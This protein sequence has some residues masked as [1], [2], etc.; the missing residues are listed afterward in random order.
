M[1]CQQQR[2]RQQGQWQHLDQASNSVL[3]AEQIRSRCKR[4]AKVSSMMGTSKNRADTFGMVR[5]CK[6]RGLPPAQSQLMFI[7]LPGAGCRSQQ[8][9]T[10]V[11]SYA[12]TTHR[13]TCNSLGLLSLACF[14]LLSRYLCRSSSMGSCRPWMTC[15]D[16][17]KTPKLL[18]DLGCGLQDLQQ[19][20]QPAN[21][22]GHR[23]STRPDLGSCRHEIAATAD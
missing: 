15:C 4:T 2:L 8:V 23:P 10:D 16:C 6:L 22:S 1:D 14:P 3:A 13:P 9:N 19:T 11:E 12:K 5:P 21:C 18:R 7:V 17:S 20:P